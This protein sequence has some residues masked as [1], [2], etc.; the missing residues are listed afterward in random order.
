M[1]VSILDAAYA[2]VPNDPQAGAYN[3]S[4]MQHAI[5]DVAAGGGGTV[6]VPDRADYHIEADAAA[7][8]L[9]ARSGVR[10]LGEG[11]HMARLVLTSVAQGHLINAVMVDDFTLEGL[12]LD[13]NREAFVQGGL[14]VHVVRG[15]ATKRLRILECDVR[16]AAYYGIGLQ[17]AA[18]SP[19]PDI[20]YII[21]RTHV[22]ECG[23]WA[24]AGPTR[25]DGIDIK[26][27][28]DGLVTETLVENCAQRG[29]D[30]RGINNRIVGNTVRGVGSSGVTA[31][32]M[33]ATT[34]GEPC[35]NPPHMVVSE[36]YINGV[37]GV[38]IVVSQETGAPDEGRFIISNNQVYSTVSD[39]I[40]VTGPTNKMRGLIEGNLLRSYG[41]QAINCPATYTNVSV[42]TNRT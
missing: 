12:S 36:N 3:R 31:R 41:G 38:G 28:R 24:A 7:S 16:G 42:G 26:F 19:L 34:A 17:C 10:L 13:G 6:E 2:A 18:T 4:A 1:H 5:D 29:I 30:V 22:R 32:G 33:H 15:Q 27:G 35:V 40:S 20:G 14:G 9:L 23:G 8:G 21:A 11:R 25:G 37:G 39:G